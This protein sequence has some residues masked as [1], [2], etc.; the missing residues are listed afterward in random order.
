M[1]SEKN[2]NIID[3]LLKC[4]LHNYQYA[5]YLFEMARNILEEDQQYSMDIANK[6]KGIAA[7]MATVDIKFFGLYNRCLLFRAPYYFEDYLLYM[8]K[9]RE[10][11]KRFY[12]PRRRTLKT[13]VDDL[14]ELEEG[15]FK[16]YGLSMPSRTGKALANNTPVLTDKGWKKHGD[17]VVGDKVINNYGD[18]VK[19]TH[20]FPKCRLNKVVRFSDGEEI[21]CHDNHE[22][23]VRDRHNGRTVK[24][25]TGYMINKVKDK[26]KWGKD[27]NRFQLNIN[28]P[29]K[30][31][32]KNLPVK[33]YALGTW[34]GDGT[35]VAPNI[36]SD[37]NDLII[38]KAIE[39][40]GYKIRKVDMCVSHKNTTKHIPDVYFSSSFNQ[41]LELLAGLLD[42]NGTLIK[43]EHRYHFSTTEEQMKDDFITLVSTFGWRTSC[44][45]AEPKLS[46]SGIQGRKKVYTIGFNPTFYIPCRLERKQ[47]H[48]FSKQKRISITD[49]YESSEEEGNCISV[50]GG[51]YLAGR[52]LKPTHNSTL[53]IFF[54]SWVMGRNPDKAN[55]MSGHSDKLTDGFF[56]ETLNFITDDTYKFD[57][58]FTNV[59]L[60][61]KSSKDEAINLNHK[62]RFPTLTCRSI[63]GT[64]TGAVEA[65]NYLY[66]D[67]LVRDRTESLSAQRLEDKY[68]SYLNVLVDRKK[69]GCKEL[70]VG[71]R[72]NVL[73]PLGRIEKQYKGNPQYRFRKLPALNEKDE[74]N[75]MYD[76]NIGFSTEYFKTIRERLDK[77]EWM[78]KYQQK[79]FI[80]EGL[81]FPEDDLNY[82]NGVLPQDGLVRVIGV[83][84]VAW[85]GGDS[86]S[87]PFAYVYDN[88]AVYIHDWIF[89]KG[90]KDVTIPIVVGTTLKH[91]PSQEHFEANNGGDMYADAIDTKLKE[92]GFHTNIT[93]CKAPNTMSKLA[94]IIQYAPEIKRFYF[95]DENHRS[96]EYQAAMDE[97]TMFVQI[98]KN[99]HDDSADALS[100][101][102]AI[103]TGGLYA[104]VEAFQRPF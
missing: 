93:S 35:N 49:I 1:L 72:W 53:C 50:E 27:R 40:E 82:Y 99:E 104:K 51:I 58:I 60:E 26:C 28:G 29:V 41:R 46:S 90:T 80:R 19:V 77:N 84:D 85:G 33:P 87:M 24:L 54:M 6:V 17:L 55:L 48:E 32:E 2:K 63:D 76:Y 92:Q 5:N 95:L 47:L 69:D 61:S 62:S 89:N 14:Q 45:V 22:W 23:V 3:R 9:D 10:P 56:D 21:K 36:T 20:V 12:L 66:C 86:L 7:R 34:L 16:F 8:E 103:I 73:D 96:K 11:Q 65:E 101:L 83:C 57:E 100:Q 38:S 15:K 68:Q 43:K 70:M 78:A 18:F 31:T 64:L 91:R 44:S 94:K 98:G 25:E 81:L 88:G 4:D 13:V 42:T 102:A 59:K 52:T 97:L 74:S 79:P 75:F 71:T 67:D 39:D 37:K 30:G